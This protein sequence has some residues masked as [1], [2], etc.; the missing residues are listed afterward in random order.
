MLSLVESSENTIVNKC[1]HLRGLKC[2]TSGNFADNFIFLDWRPCISINL[3][4]RQMDS[5]TIA[6]NS[7]DVA[8]KL[9][10][11]NA[12]MCTLHSKPSNDSVIRVSIN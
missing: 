1:P 2:M 8:F 7:A 6:C 4:F 9:T 3:M 11:D 10:S 5:T 12:L